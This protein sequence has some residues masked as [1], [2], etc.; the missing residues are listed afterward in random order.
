MIDRPEHFFKAVNQLIQSGAFDTVGTREQLQAAHLEVAR[1]I[2]HA[3][4]NG[5]TPSP[6]VTLV[7]ALFIRA[8]EQ[9]VTI[10]P[11]TE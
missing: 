7:G 8:V 10:E 2:F 6:C 5:T 4:A 11:E 9:T 3:A 1:A